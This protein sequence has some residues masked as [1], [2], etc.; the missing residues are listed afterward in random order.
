MGKLEGIVPPIITPILDNEDIDE[1]HLRKIV[2][3]CIDNG[4][5]GILVA[6]SGGEAMALTQRQRM[7]AIRIALDEAQGRVPVICGAMD[8]GTRQVV[9]NIKQIE[10][11]GG[12]YVAVTPVFYTKTSNQD[13]IVRHF[14][15]ISR[16]TAL[17]VF[18][19]NIP[20]NTQVNILPETVRRIARIDRV[21]GLK[22]S[23]GI[24]PQFEKVLH[25]FKQD[26]NFRIFQGSTEI[27]GVSILCGAVG[28]VPI[29]SVFFPKLFR[30]LYEKA[31]AKDIEATLMLQHIVNL[32]S[33]KLTSRG[34]NILSAKAIA[35]M[36]G[37]GSAKVCDPSMPITAEEY[38]GI[39]KVVSAFSSSIQRAMPDQTLSGA[40]SLRY[41]DLA[42]ALNL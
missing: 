25:A 17:N 29:Y 4:L 26:D 18:I 28:Y 38:A 15:Q 8:T 36:M 31:A 35:Q 16:Q 6:G 19:Y 14:E 37:L 21:V 24:W 39:Q 30:K 42:Q 3:H 11:L 2:S 9:E 27:A 33:V 20:L 7:N 12:E 1:F 13:D 34:N 41:D 32:L 23:S 22:D 10:Q 5:H 40:A